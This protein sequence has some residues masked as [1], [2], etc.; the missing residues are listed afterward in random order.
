MVKTNLMISLSN[1]PMS[2]AILRKVSI[3]FY[4]IEEKNL[5][6]CLSN[7]DPWI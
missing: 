7:D 2:S 6:F 3:F 1:F 4:I 5:L